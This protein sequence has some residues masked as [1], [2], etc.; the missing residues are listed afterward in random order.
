MSAGSQTHHPSPGDLA[1]FALDDETPAEAAEHLRDCG[2][3]R[4]TL[5]QFRRVTE[6]G[7][8]GATDPV[9]PPAEMWETIRDQL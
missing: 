6:A 2:S 8:A 1:L 3:C 5:A 9:R 7:R 4:S